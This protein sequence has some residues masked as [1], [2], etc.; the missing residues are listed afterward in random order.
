MKTTNEV[1]SFKIFFPYDSWCLCR[2]NVHAIY[3]GGGRRKEGRVKTLQLYHDN[4]KQ[5]NSKCPEVTLMV[6]LLTIIVNCHMSRNKVSDTKCHYL[7]IQFWDF[8]PHLGVILVEL[9]CSI[10]I[11]CLC[12]GYKMVNKLSLRVNTWHLTL[13]C[14]KIYFSSISKCKIRI[15]SI[16]MCYTRHH[17]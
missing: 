1:K 14:L 5:I 6:K 12:L 16:P 10:I 4:F 13:I 9:V 3:W 7:Y 2:V 17:K 11:R 15:S 8:E